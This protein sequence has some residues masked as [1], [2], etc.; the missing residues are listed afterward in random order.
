MKSISIAAAVLCAS[1]CSSAFAWFGREPH[2]GTPP[3]GL[4]LQGNMSV[5]VFA[6]SVKCKDKNKYV[7]DFGDGSPKS[8]PT[9]ALSSVT[10][11]YEK[12]GTYTVKSYI[13]RKD[14]S[15]A[16]HVEKNINIQNE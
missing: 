7:F 3:F 10:H 16:P 8:E 1:L 2:C 5:S 6:S 4:D 15:L 13:L 9:P 11:T 12:P 14:G